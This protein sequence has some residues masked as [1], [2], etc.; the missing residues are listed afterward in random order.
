MMVQV[1][2]TE[3]LFLDPSSCSLFAKKDS[4]LC[5][6]ISFSS[7]HFILFSLKCITTQML[8]TYLWLRVY[9]MFKFEH[10]PLLFSRQGWAL[11]SFPAIDNRI[12]VAHWFRNV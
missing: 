1:L 5:F 4:M 6:R 8:G 3:E 11:F 10:H 2:Y 7:D 12:P 9:F